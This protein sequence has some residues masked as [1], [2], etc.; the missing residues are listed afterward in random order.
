[1]KRISLDFYYFSCK[2]F[3]EFEPTEFKFNYIFVFE[4]N[5]LVESG[6]EFFFKLENLNGDYISY[7][8]RGHSELGKFNFPE[9]KYNE[10]KEISSIDN[11]LD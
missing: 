3:D 9:I 11:I 10:Y 4:R 7:S 5:L 6:I 8:V 2:R 1:M